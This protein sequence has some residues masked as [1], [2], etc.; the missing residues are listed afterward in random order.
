MKSFLLVF[1]LMSAATNIAFSQSANTPQQEAPI[2][3]STI[4]VKGITCSNDLAMITNNVEKLEGVNSCKIKKKGV[5]SKFKVTFNPEL[6]T[7]K[8]IHAA[9]EGTGSC[10][11]PDERPYK[12]KL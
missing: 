1:I 10:E 6:V 2:K 7:E 12:V 8:A 9:I 3:V 11:N 4:K 5:T